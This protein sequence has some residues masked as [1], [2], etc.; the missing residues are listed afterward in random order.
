MYKVYGSENSPYSIKVRAYCDY[1][2]IP[3]VWLLRGQHQ[4]GECSAPAPGSLADCSGSGS[5]RLRP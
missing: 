2:E 3:H 4:E 1:K 5:L